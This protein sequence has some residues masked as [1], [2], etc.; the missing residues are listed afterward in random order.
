MHYVNYSSRTRNVSLKD[1]KRKVFLYFLEFSRKFIR[2]LKKSS[3]KNEEIKVLKIYQDRKPELIRKNNRI[4]KENRITVNLFKLTIFI[5]T[6]YIPINLRGN[7]RMDEGS[8]EVQNN[9]V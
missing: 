6:I 7:S 3:R 2:D 1:K 4:Y 9:N 5:Y 8:I